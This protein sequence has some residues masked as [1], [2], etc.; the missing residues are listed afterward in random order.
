MVT[1]KPMRKKNRRK[2]LA[3]GR[4]NRETTK[5]EGRKVT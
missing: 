5:N 4:K 1:N 3:E 2:H